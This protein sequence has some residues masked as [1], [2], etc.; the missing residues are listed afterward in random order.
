MVLS[1]SIVREEASFDYHQFISEEKR[2]NIR[3]LQQKKSREQLADRFV[4]NNNNPLSQVKVSNRNLHSDELK[5][6]LL[7]GPTSSFNVYDDKLSQRVE[8]GFSSPII[9][10]E[11]KIQVLSEMIMMDL[12][13]SPHEIKQM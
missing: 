1:R 13:R 12:T 3:A 9:P 11:E 4:A 6:S 8:T 7:L 2:A 10:S 5:L